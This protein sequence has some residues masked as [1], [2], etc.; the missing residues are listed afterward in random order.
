MADHGFAD[1]LCLAFGLS[2]V[3][4]STLK[5]VSKMENT[6]DLVLAN[7][8]FWRKIDSVSDYSVRNEYSLDTLGCAGRK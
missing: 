7:S 1:S 6:Q 4:L 2:P 3:L 5:S 8:Y